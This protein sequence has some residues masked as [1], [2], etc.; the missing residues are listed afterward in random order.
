MYIPSINANEPKI[1]FHKQ[2]RINT[3]SPGDHVLAQ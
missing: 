1:E 2:N 3:A